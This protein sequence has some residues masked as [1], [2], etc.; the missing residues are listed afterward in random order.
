MSNELRVDSDCEEGETEE[1]LYGDYSKYTDNEHFTGT[2]RVPT[3]IKGLLKIDTDVT[4]FTHATEKLGLKS[5]GHNHSTSTI[6]YSDVPLSRRKKISGNS[7]NSRN[8]T[9]S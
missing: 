1:K 8:Y 4:D 3:K 5:L 9:S 6:E 7:S 2:I